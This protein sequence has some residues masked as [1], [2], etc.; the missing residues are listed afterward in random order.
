MVSLGN[1][2]CL[3][4]KKADK[5]DKNKQKLTLKKEETSFNE[6]FTK[7]KKTIVVTTNEKSLVHCK[8]KPLKS[9]LLPVF[10]DDLNDTF[11]Q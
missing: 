1:V 5:R 9:E 3:L 6:P 7:K 8:K 10:D 4:F 11:S 2:S